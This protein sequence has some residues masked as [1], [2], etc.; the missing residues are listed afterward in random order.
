MSAIA[1]LIRRRLEIGCSY[2]KCTN[3]LAKT[4]DNC[5]RVVGYYIQGSY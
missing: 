5:R 2:G 4:M 1:G 3:V